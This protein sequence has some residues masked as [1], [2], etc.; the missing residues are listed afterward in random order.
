MS[1]FSTEFASAVSADVLSTFGDP[2]TLWANGQQADARTITGSLSWQ[3]EFLD[4]QSGRSLR[5]RGDITVAAGSGITR[6]DLFVIG[7]GLYSVI[8]RSEPANGLEYIVIQRIDG[9]LRREAR[10]TL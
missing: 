5:R 2:L 8:S 1:E 9:E 3:E 10:K 4:E 6:R 7:E